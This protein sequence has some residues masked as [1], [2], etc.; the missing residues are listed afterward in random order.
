M[1]FWERKFS[2]GASG[3]VKKKERKRLVWQY[4]Q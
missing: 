2:L 4:P 1:V 3:E